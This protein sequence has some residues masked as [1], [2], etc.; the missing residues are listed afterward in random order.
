MGG[1][2]NY[3]VGPFRVELLGR[4]GP[5]ITEVVVPPFGRV[6]ADTH[7]APLTLRASLQEV[8]ATDLADILPPRVLDTIALDVEREGLVALRAYVWRSLAVVAIGAAVAG[9]LVYRTRWR[10]ALAA[11]VSGFVLFASATGIAWLTYRPDAFLQPTFTGSLSLAPRLVGPIREATGRI[12]D[13]RAELQRLVGGAIQ[14]YSRIAATQPAAESDV[15]LLHVSDI[16]L[17]PIG[18]DFAERLA[19]AF[20]VDLVVDTGD[21]T[22]FGTPVEVGITERI[23]SFGVPYVFVRGNHDSATTVAQ[24]LRQENAVALVG[25]AREVAG[26]I[27]F[28]AS[29]P[30]F[31]PDK[32]EAVSDEEFAERAR[33]AGGPILETLAALPTPPDIVAVHDDRMAEALTGFV[34]LVVSGHFHLTE[35]RTED[36]TLFLRVG[37]TGGGGFDLITAPEPIPLAA[38]VLYLDGDPPRLVA[39]DEVELDP[40]S[41]NLTVRRRLTSELEEAG[42]DEPAPLGEPVPTP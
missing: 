6:R 37:S 14:A 42:T 4:P 18:M 30:V 11:G 27:I 17:S 8:A 2:G 25:E 24:V 1:R 29:H 16:H 26:L 21:L 15:V 3:T 36:G 22:S 41:Q 9:L 38:E 28:G 7:F 5:G 32:R 23:G 12:E 40:I 31:T 39:W 19:A 13:F 10:R 33:G 35:A 20:E 34:P